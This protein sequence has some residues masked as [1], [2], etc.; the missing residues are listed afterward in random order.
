MAAKGYVIDLSGDVAV[1]TGAGSGIGRAIALQLADA[2]ANVVCGD[3]NMDGASATA[4]RI[5]TSGGQAEAV[6]MDMSVPAE[7]RSVLKTVA[8]RSG[9]LD[10]LVNN[11]GVYPFAPMADLEDET[12]NL[13]MAVNVRGAFEAMRTAAG[14]MASGGRIVNI[15]SI[16]SLRPSSPGLGHYGASKA[17]VNALTR[18]GSVE[19]GPRGIR[20][21]ALLPGVIAT[22]GTSL[23]PEDARNVWAERAPAQ[24][25][26]APEDIAR[27]AL[28][29]VSPLA[30]FMH[31]A[32]MVVDGGLTING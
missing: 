4:E 5:R 18:S 24:R 30:G 27:A 29:L 8:E 1:V 13:V 11:A 23:T 17:A 31:G 15:S 20:V 10:I 26:G 14:M 28:Y 9:R 12:W 19:Y 3:V 7:I 21:N 22:E 32:S 16:D 2:G 25:I 6:R